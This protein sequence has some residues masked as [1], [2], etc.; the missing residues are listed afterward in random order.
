MHR[1]SEHYVTVAYFSLKSRYYLLLSFI[2]VTVAPKYV[3]NELFLW[4]ENSYP[5]ITINLIVSVKTY[6]IERGWNYGCDCFKPMSQ[7]CIVACH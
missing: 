3:T 5:L 2:V 1:S 6:L 7:F 4:A